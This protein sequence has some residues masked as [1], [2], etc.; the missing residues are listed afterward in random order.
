MNKIFLYTFFAAITLVSLASCKKNNLVIGKEITPPAFAKIG[1][2]TASDS[3]GIYI[4]KSTNE[5]FKIPIGVTNVSDK[6]RT[7]NL[8]YSSTTAVAGVNYT[9]PASLVIKAGEALDSL[10]IAGLF[11]GFNNDV[12]RVDKLLITITGGD[13]PANSVKYNYVLTMKM[14]WET[15]LNAF[16]GD[17]IIQDYYNGAPEGGPYEVILTP[18]S[19]NGPQSVVSIKGLWGVDEPLVN[20]ILN[21]SDRKTGTT[22]IV[23]ANWFTDPDYGQSTI[24][25]NKTGTFSV[26][27]NKM[28]IG[29]EATVDAGSFGKYVSVLIKK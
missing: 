8:S 6:D 22:S 17:Y 29:W 19:L 26:V 12:T 23:K 13:I 5:P 27:D 1:T 11:E 10:E 16:A 3:T 18:V 9:A 25:P 14:Y 28:T 21:W 2:W 7:I 20:V 24:N 4:V 15:D